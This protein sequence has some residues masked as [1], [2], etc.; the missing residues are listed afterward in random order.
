MISIPR[1]LKYLLSL[2]WT[3]YSIASHSPWPRGAQGLVSGIPWEGP[4]CLAWGSSYIKGACPPQ[5]CPSSS[6]RWRT[7]AHGPITNCPSLRRDTSLF[8]SLPHQSSLVLTQCLAPGRYSHEDRALKWTAWGSGELRA[9]RTKVVFSETVLIHVVLETVSLVDF[10]PPTNL[11][12][13]KENSVL[14]HVISL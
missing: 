4:Q 2:P 13:G 3:V 8:I 14:L 5:T 6:N 11:K 10:L 9:D 7:L 1:F 12:E